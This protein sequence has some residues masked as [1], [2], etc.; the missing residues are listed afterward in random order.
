MA[1]SRHISHLCT[2]IWLFRNN[3]PNGGLVSLEEESDPL[4]RIVFL[5]GGYD[6]RN[7]QLLITAT[8]T[9]SWGA[10]PELED[11]PLNPHY[12][13]E[14]TVKAIHITQLR[15]AIMHCVHTW[16]CPLTGG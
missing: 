8:V 11:N 4:R 13:G 3:L 16:G 15:S 1:D 10:P 5:S 2:A 6:Y 12:S 14:T 9:T 7:G